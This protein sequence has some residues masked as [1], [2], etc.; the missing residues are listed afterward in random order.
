MRSATHRPLYSALNDMASPLDWKPVLVAGTATSA[1]IRSRAYSWFHKDLDEDPKQSRDL[2]RLLKNVFSSQTDED[3]V[4]FAEAYADAVLSLTDLKD[5]IW[6]RKGVWLKEGLPTTLY[7]R[8]RDHS[9]HTMHNYLL[10][11]YFFSNSAIIQKE[12]LRLFDARSMPNKFDFILWFGEVWCFASLLHDVGYLF[13]GQVPDGSM[14]LIDDGI[15]SGV[16]WA[17]EYFEHRFWNEC[18][19]QRADERKQ[20][21]KLADFEPN[22]IPD[23]G[24]GTVAEFL[25]DLGE[26]DHLRDAIEGEGLAMPALPGDAFALWRQNYE[27]FGNSDMA[28]RIDRMEKQFYSLMDQGIPKL[29]VRVLD[30]GVCSGLLLLKYSTFWFR[31]IFSLRSKEAKNDPTNLVAKILEVVD[32]RRSYMAS[33]W[34]RSVVW[35]TAA[36]AIHNIQQ[37]DRAPGA[38]PLTLSDDPLVFLG[39]LVDLLEEWDRPSAR[40]TG[41]VESDRRRINGADMRVGVTSDG[42]ISLKYGCR[43]GKFRERGEEMTRELDHALAGWRDVVELS[44]ASC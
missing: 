29:A 8:H 33:H 9:V 43:D 13:E 42:K 44:F 21:R 17:T 1:E 3:R 30:H 12:F 10:G 35:S 23:A 15:R 24:P 40:R 4:H 16:V 26:L 39:I 2:A 11:W 34:W 22:S 25:R 28:A 41:T 6:F 36:C 32:P 37:T 27:V 18:Q 5:A 20:I 38:M 31:L 7:H 19:L 14:A